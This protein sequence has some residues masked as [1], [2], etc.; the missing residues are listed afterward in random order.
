[1]SE[2]SSELEYERPSL[3][4]TAIVL[5]GAAGCYLAFA[6]AT[7]DAIREIAG[8]LVAGAV[9]SGVVVGF[10]DRREGLRWKVEQKRE[11]NRA[12][13]DDMRE[14]EAARL[15]WH[16]EVDLRTLVI[17]RSQLAVCRTTLH[18]T[19]RRVLESGHAT[20]SR[21]LSAPSDLSPAVGLRFTEFIEFRQEILVLG[22][23]SSNP[24]VAGAV[25]LWGKASNFDEV[26]RLQ[27]PSTGQFRL[28]WVT[29]SLDEIGEWLETE[30]VSWD[31]ARAMLQRHEL[32]A[33]GKPPAV[34]PLDPAA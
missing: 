30:E 17:A 32:A 4:Y 2:S 29:T 19:I 20:G 13:A 22:E 10:E 8:A 5:L 7:N 16:R 23:M 24:E 28:A 3:F 9:I 11:A 6:Y 18:R 25:G 15:A 31:N 12:E 27:R 14:V 34:I 1:M 21:D 26:F 33:Y